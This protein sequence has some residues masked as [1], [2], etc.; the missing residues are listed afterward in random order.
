MLEMVAI[1]SVGAAGRAHKRTTVILAE[2]S[3]LA[4]PVQCTGHPPACV[5]SSTTRPRPHS[6]RTLTPSPTSG[7]QAVTR[8]LVAA[9]SR[10]LPVVQVVGLGSGDGRGRVCMAT[11]IPSRDQQHVSDAEVLDAST[12]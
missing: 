8:S 1:A 2:R 11:I 5:T 6:A 7:R 4:S 12:Q 9:C 10:A 3:P